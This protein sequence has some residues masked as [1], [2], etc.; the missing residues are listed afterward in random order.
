[1]TSPQVP[2]VLVRRGALLLAESIDVMEAVDCL[3]REVSDLDRT[4]DVLAGEHPGMEH[5][6]LSCEWCDRYGWGDARLVLVAIA[7][8]IT[9]ATAS[10]FSA[11]AEE[12]PSSLRTLLL[13]QKV[14]RGQHVSTAAEE[15]EAKVAALE[16]EVALRRAASAAAIG[17]LASAD[18][19]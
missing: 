19:G 8:R 16:H 12:T 18:E 3:L 13:D 14:A 1:M 17:A 6:T 9:N 7:D 4:A 10:R 5:E 11:Y 2:D 15:L